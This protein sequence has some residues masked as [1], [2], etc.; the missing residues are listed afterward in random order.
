M[1]HLTPLIAAAAL[2]I[3]GATS[4]VSDE[5]VVGISLLS[6]G[7]IMSGAW[8]AQEVRKNQDDYPPQDR[9]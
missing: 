4:Y 6:A 8:L 7:L 2:L 5:T 3:G 1:R 9:R